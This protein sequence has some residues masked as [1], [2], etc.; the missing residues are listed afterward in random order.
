ML[1]RCL[2]ASRATAAV[3]D[4]ALDGILRQSRR[5]NLSRGITGMLC[6]A[7]GIFVQVIEGGR[8]DVSGLM[9]RIFADTRHKDVQVLLFEEIGQRR[10]GSWT[11]GQ[12]NL[13]SVNPGLLLKYFEKAELNPFAAAGTATMS[14]LFEIAET[15]AIGHR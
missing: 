14:L 5:N 9:S 4:A 8:A 12:A 1:V 2:Y 13:A 6:H 10:F 3:T 15:G 11:M 7:N